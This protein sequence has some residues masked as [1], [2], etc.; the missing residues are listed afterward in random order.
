M[1]TLRSVPPQRDI[2]TVNHR[3]FPEPCAD[4]RPTRERGPAQEI[5]QT[6]KQFMS[7]DENDNHDQRDPKADGVDKRQVPLLS[8]VLYQPASGDACDQPDHPGKRGRDG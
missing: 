6:M 1:T 7:R 4:P 2:D 3:V 5:A 8:A